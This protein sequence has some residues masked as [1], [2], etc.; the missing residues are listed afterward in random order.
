MDPVPHARTQ[1][2]AETLL[3]GS[4]SSQVRGYGGTNRWD[5]RERL[6]R[7]H[8]Q[9]RHRHGDGDERSP[10]TH[11]FDAFVEKL[12]YAQEEVHLVKRN[13]RD[14]PGWH[15]LNAL[16]RSLY[17]ETIRDAALCD[18]LRERRQQE[19]INPLILASLFVLGLLSIHP[20]N[21]G[22]GWM[23]RL[24]TLMLL[25]HYG[26]KVEHYISLEQIVESRKEDYYDL[27]RLSS[28]RWHQNQ[29]DPFT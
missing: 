2:I 16:T 12:D 19:D 15:S 9:R 28:I 25:Y 26:F 1:R 5:D 14:V 24:L 11:R 27:L 20:F 21:N 4:A 17:S 8:L 10:L 6:K 29:Q 22:N 7:C 3:P 18:S 13:H 23:A